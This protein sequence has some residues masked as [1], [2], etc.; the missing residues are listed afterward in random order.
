MIRRILDVIAPRQCQICN[1]RLAIDEELICAACNMHLPR[2][3]Y[4]ANAY[5]NPMA[6]LFWGQ[7]PI[8]RAAAWFFYESH[9]EVSKMIYKLKYGDHPEYGYLI[10]QFLAEDFQCDG[11]FD[12]ID[13]IVPIPISRKRKWSRGYNQSE[14]I[15]KGIAIVT[16]LPVRTDIVKRNSFIASQTH[17]NWWQRHGNVENAFTLKKAELARDKHLLIVDDVITTGSTILSCSKE[18]CRAGNVKI[19]VATIGFAGKS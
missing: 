18:I 13:A 4:S 8:E 1:K 3:L 7:I 11:F 12:G 2:T 9:S 10:G 15:A 16:G 17:M 6:R 14:H 5:D 19:S